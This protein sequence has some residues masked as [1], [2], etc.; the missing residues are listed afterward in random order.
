MEGCVPKRI[1][2]VHSILL[3]IVQWQK[4]Y[5]IVL[6]QFPRPCSIKLRH[7]RIENKSYKDK[8]S[9][10]C[11]FFLHFQGRISWETPF[12]HSQGQVCNSSIRS[13][14]DANW[15]GKSRRKLTGN[16]GVVTRVKKEV[17]L[18]EKWKRV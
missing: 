13:N 10:V 12:H 2:T 5:V 14:V 3:L 1:C 15:H 9:L 7:S 16:V 18:D 6:G 11:K 8:Y 17:Y 4:H